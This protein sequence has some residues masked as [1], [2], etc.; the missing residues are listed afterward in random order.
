MAPPHWRSKTDGNA[1]SFAYLHPTT[2]SDIHLLLPHAM[3]YCAP[4]NATATLAPFAHGSASEL[5]KSIVK[6]P[7]VIQLDINGEMQS[8]ASNMTVQFLAKLQ[9]Y[10]TLSRHR[11][12]CTFLRLLENVGIVLSLVTAC[13]TLYEII[14]TRPSLM[15]AQNFEYYNQ[16]LDGFTHLNSY[17][18]SHGE[19][20]LLYIQ[21]TTP[22]HKIKLL[23][24]GQ[25]VSADSTLKLPDDEPVDPFLYLG[26]WHTN[27]PHLMQKILLVRVEQIY[28]GTRPFSAPEIL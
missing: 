18:L 24:F 22:T 26:K 10:T 21:M 13:R 20:S 2:S 23:D 12:I 16:L 3:A 25:S 14:I 7:S 27:A 5:S 1:A 6:N 15:P 11:D 19:V 28:P 8:N 4:P 9:V 17:G